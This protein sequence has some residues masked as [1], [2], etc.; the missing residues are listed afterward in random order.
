MSR[1]FLCAPLH[2]NATLPVHHAVFKHSIRRYI[3]ST[4][5]SHKVLLKH[6]LAMKKRSER[7][8]MMTCYDASQAALADLAQIDT[9]LVGDSCAN[10]MMGLK[11]TNQ[12][13]MDAMVHHIEC[14]SRGLHRGYL[15][16]DMPFGSYLTPE[17]AVRNA[18][19]LVSEGGASCVKL[20]GFVPEAIREISRFIPVCAHLGLLPQTTDCF[21]TRGRTQRDIKQ[22]LEQSLKLQ[23][24]GASLL[25]LEKVAAETAA[26]IS[27]SLDIPTIGIGSGPHC[28]GQ[29]LVWHDMLGLGHPSQDTYK[30]V[31][32]Y[33]DLAPSIVAA[34]EGYID[35]VKS[36]SFP[37]AKHS[38]FLPQKTHDEM[39][40]DESMLNEM[41]I[42]PESFFDGV[43]S[44]N[45]APEI[46]KSAAELRRKRNEMGSQKVA[47]IPFLGGLHSGHLALIEAAKQREP[48][49]AIWCSLFLNPL[50]FNDTADYLKYPYDA[51]EDIAK[52]TEIGVDLIYSP[53]VHEM[54]PHLA[55]GDGDGEGT[56]SLFTPFVDFKGIEMHSEEGRNRPGHFQGVGT[57]LTTLFASIRPNIAVFGQKD[58]MQ[59]VVVRNLCRQLFPETEIVVHPTMREHDGLAMS[60]RNRK[61]SAVERERAPLIHRTLSAIGC[62]LFERLRSERG[63]IVT[64]NAAI[65]IGSE[66]AKHHNVDLEYISFHRFSDG[67]K[68]DD[69]EDLIPL[70]QRQQIVISIAGSV[71]GST[72][73]IDNVVIGGG[74]EQNKS[75]WA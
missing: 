4:A 70:L 36:G 12:I 48:T 14:V 11:N 68:L 57:V 53:S 37:S 74:E 72:R 10:V 62:H 22:L 59:C 26:R 24:E 19:R 67:L 29:V 69:D 55:D 45:A 5:K 32:R 51:E 46:I 13:T 23:D 3:D 27:Q 52:L 73:L 16:G 33:A 47:F 63:D 40:G 44:K 38:Y 60:S 66:F 35:E 39:K 28:D 31:K 54:Y 64:V 17:D 34:I 6:L 61:L 9:V 56:N 30:F 8:T 41:D 42:D 21:G 20:E 15:I 49:L 50:Q 1:F 25:V 18:A 2:G 71:G 75:L 58:F 7:I 43:C 65:V